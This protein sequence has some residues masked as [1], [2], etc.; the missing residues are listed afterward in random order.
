MGGRLNSSAA[1]G[2]VCP[3]ENAAELHNE[4]QCDAQQQQQQSGGASG[5]GDRQ[6]LDTTTR[7]DLFPL[8]AVANTGLRI[9]I[10]ARDFRSSATCADVWGD[11][12]SSV[13][14]QLW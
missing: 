11:R 7:L 2:Y 9:N 1:S 13:G 4:E 10:R 6:A 14:G 3:V 5:T 8:L 12:A